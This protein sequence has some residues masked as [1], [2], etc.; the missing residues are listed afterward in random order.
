MITVLDNVL[1]TIVLLASVAYAFATL[2]PQT[3][4]RRAFGWLAGM[5]ARAPKA[6]KLAWVA[7]QLAQVADDEAK[8]ACGGC[9]RC[10]TEPSPQ[11]SSAE[12]R[13]PIASI[14]RS[15]PSQ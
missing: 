10:G 12:I 1:V 7:Q 8:G 11:N 9:E 5:L 13:I 14:S 4:R 2:S 6:L 15:R 3:M